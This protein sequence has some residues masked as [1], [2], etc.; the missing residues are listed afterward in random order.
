MIR[1]HACNASGER[2]RPY[3]PH[4]SESPAPSA[5]KL[6]IVEPI[7]KRVLVRKDD[8]KKQ[9]KSGLHLPDKIEIPTLTG[10]I[11]TLSAE[12]ENDTNYP[13]KQYDRVL[14]NPK[15]AIPIDFESDNRL[16]VIPVENVVAVL[17]N[18]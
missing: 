7:G 16:F 17:R 5:K 6:E 2:G 11:V 1:Q 3:N 15:G 12:V 13:I 10:R 4:M 8:D 9:T 18:A 14:F